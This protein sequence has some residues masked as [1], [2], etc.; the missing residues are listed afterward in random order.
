MTFSKRAFIEWLESKTDLTR[1]GRPENTLHCPLCEFLKET[2]EA[3]YVRMSFELRTVDGVFTKNPMW[4]QKFQ[5]AASDFVNDI[6]GT[7]QITAK[8]ALS[9][10]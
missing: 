6:E 10:L 7:R 2:Q 1:V 5:R 4:A 8:R 3:R 9:F